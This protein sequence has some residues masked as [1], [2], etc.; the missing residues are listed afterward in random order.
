MAKRMPQVTI[1]PPD[2]PPNSATFVPNLPPDLNF[3]PVP[4][5]KSRSNGR[6]PE[7][8]RIFIAM[9]A[10]CGS[11]ATACKAVGC[12]SYAVYHLRNRAGAESFATAWDRAVERGARRV[13]D[14]LIDHAINGVPEFIYKEGEIVGERRHFNTRAQMWIVAHYL[15]ERFGVAGGLMHATQGPL[16]VKRLKEQWRREQAEAARTGRA[17]SA[18]KIGTMISAIRSHFKTK[19]AD[20]LAKRAAWELLTGTTDWSDVT[21]VTDYGWGPKLPDAN[22][23]RPDLIMTMAMPLV[24]DGR[25]AADV[26]FG[27]GEGEDDQTSSA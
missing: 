22:Q 3:T 2:A 1:L 27:G 5:R 18:E 23:N 20:D 16:N 15:P 8:Q 9:L 10:Q 26:L 11:V 24:D 21:K 7:R 12:S 19:L 25:T 13:L 17:Q 14:V 6:T 4:R